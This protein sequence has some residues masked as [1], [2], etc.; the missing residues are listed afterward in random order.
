MRII[1]CALVIFNHLPGYMLY[2]TT[3]G[4]R[5]FIY[6]CITMI[7]RINVPLFFMISGALLFQKNE[8]MVTV[9]RKRV[10]RIAGIL[11]LFNI[12]MVFIQKCVAIDAGTEYHITFAS[13]IRDFLRN[14][15][16]GTDSYWYLYSYLGIL[17]A[18]PFLQRM[19]KGITKTEVCV[20]AFI[21]FISSSFLPVANILMKQYG[22]NG[23]YALSGNFVVP[24]AFEKAF[25]YTIVG[26]YLEYHVQIEKIKRKHIVLLIAAASAGI[27]ISN[28]CTYLDWKI[29]GE[30]SQ[31]Y[32]QLFDYITTITAFII[33]KYLF[34]MKKKAD[35][36]RGIK[37]TVCFL[38]SMTFGIYLLDPCL[39]ML[40]YG[41]YEAA[42]S[43]T[44][45]T[46]IISAGWILISMAL[47]TFITWI[48]RKIP[49][50][51]VLS[52]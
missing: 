5:Q 31:N 36:H 42:V 2:S 44:L 19:A 7:T 1:A 52:I 49:V 17:V 11:I 45:P 34:V 23:G 24:F 13:F 16:P 38:G 32:V 37:K 43:R 48:S 39:R 28:A 9:F 30:Y 15:I 47:G 21:H 22:K 29:N 12:I 20:L 3:T 35:S 25:F 40:F 41:R 27:L 10:L 33:I 4:V 46:L 14:N 51:R 8:D 26:Y 50:I 18:L 6:M